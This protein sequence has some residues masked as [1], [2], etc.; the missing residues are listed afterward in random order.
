MTSWREVA[1]YIGFGPEDSARLLDL[2]PWAE[3]QLSSIA[4]RFYAAIQANETT[5]AVLSG[6]AQVERLKG[7]LVQWM[8]E[9]LAGPHEEAYWARRRLIGQVHVRVGLPNQYVFGAMNIIRREL[10]WLANKHLDEDQAQET[11]LALQR[12]TDIELA[13]MSGT[14]M[15]AHEAQALVGLQAVIVENLPTTVLCL[16]ADLRVTSAS[17]APLPGCEGLAAYLDPALIKA[18]ELQD[19]LA[20]AIEHGRQVSLP[21]VV[22]PLQRH[23]H[24]TILPLEHPMARV[25]V[26]VDEVTDSVR[27]E[28]RLRESEHLAQIGSLAANVAHEIRNPLAAINATLQVIVGSLPPTDDRRG[29]LDA[30]Q[31]HVHRLDCLVTDLLSFARPVETRSQ[32]IDL[33]SVAR[34]AAAQSAAEPKL[35]LPDA[36]CEGMGDAFYLQQ[37]LVN[38]LQ[39]AR[40]AAGS[41][42]EVLLRVCADATIRVV[43]SGPGIDPSLEGRLFEPFVTTK[44]RGTGLGLAISRKLARAMGGELILAAVQ[45]SLGGA[46]FELK[47]LEAP[48][49]RT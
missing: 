11:V 48:L 32:L 44:A 14:W 29:V 22:T 3:P 42:G 7:T 20:R 47:L 4:D 2:M 21:R 5:A 8:R 1:N 23:Y 25:L 40:D 10:I 31:G 45:G 16:D 33:A 15:E 9:L 28:A 26:H 18:S 30:V 19:Q 38:L 27:L 39:N 41:T 35:S 17:R 36:Q 6:P 12:V 46:E 34:V 24:V 13:V 43:D 37:I 49:H